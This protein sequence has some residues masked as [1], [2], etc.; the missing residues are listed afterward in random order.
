[1]KIYKLIFK[2][3]IVYVGKTKLSLKKRKSSGYGK[4]V[5]FF[6]ECDIELIEETDDDSRERFWIS[7]YLS[8]GCPLLNKF[9][10]N[11]F[12]KKLYYEDNKEYY[13]N[14]REEHRECMKE[15]AK[16]YYEKNKDEIKEYRKNYYMNNLDSIKEYGKEYY[17]ENKEKIKDKQK[18]Y[19]EKNKEKLKEYRREYYRKKKS[20]NEF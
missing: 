15:Y 14:W 12:D 1:M 17:E 8:M 3:E 10:G 7:Y 5:P 6:K 20:Q 18:E 11:G 19:K 16:D 2:G 13:E 4:N 9:K